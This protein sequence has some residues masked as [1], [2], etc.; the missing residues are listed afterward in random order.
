MTPS[1]PYRA[2]RI[3]QLPVCGAII[4]GIALLGL[5]GVIPAAYSASISATVLAGLAAVAFLWSG[6]NLLSLIFLLYTFLVLIVAYPAEYMQEGA[7]LFLIVLL[8]FC[9]GRTIDLFQHESTAG[10]VREIRSESRIPGVLIAGLVLQAAALLYLLSTY[11]IKGFYSGAYMADEIKNYSR[12]SS[13]ALLTAVIYVGTLLGIAGVGIYVSRGKASRYL[14]GFALLGM[15]LLNLA[16]SEIVAG[17]ICITYI[18]RRSIKLWHIFVI[19]VLALFCAVFIGR[20]RQSQLQG[21]AANLS[22]LGAIAGELSVSQCVHYIMED[23]HTDGISGGASLVGPVITMPIPR[24]IFPDKPELTSARIMMKYL[25]YDAENGFY[26]APTIF[27]DWLYNF[28]Y[29][30]LLIISLLL[31]LMIRRIDKGPVS[32]VG[33]VFSYAIFVIL[34]NN[35]AQSFLFVV[36]CFA[37]REMDR[38]KIVSHSR[39]SDPSMPRLPAQ[40][41]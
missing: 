31:G 12:G 36:V 38:F 35:T 23:I 24:A 2:L 17:G 13:N 20:L 30:G 10:T 21:G 34:R 33:V 7:T 28:G 16:R 19:A 22:T 14:V 4:A 8:G 39:S 9:L 6:S 32:F 11:G 15:P 25:P 5:V 37:V 41:I 18:Y 40:G 26:L 27:G 1:P 3:A 29:P